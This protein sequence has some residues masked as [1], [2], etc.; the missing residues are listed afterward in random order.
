MTSESFFEIIEK[1]YKQDLPF[2]IYKKAE[3]SKVNAFLQNDAKAHIVNDFT[4]RGF[5]MSPFDS[6]KD[7]ILLPLS[8]SRQIELDHLNLEIF[9][10]QV[11][12]F[13]TETE[14]DKHKHIQLVQKGIDAIKSNR[15][16]KVVLSRKESVE[17][18]DNNPMGIY[19]KLLSSYPNAFV[20]CWYHP[21]F[22]LWLGATPETLV[23]IENNRLITMSL[24]GTKLY[25]GSL[26]IDWS[27]K[28][29]QEQQIVTDYIVENVTPHLTNLS[30]SDVKT[31]RAGS[32]VHLQT[33]ISGTLKPEDAILGKVISGLHPTPAV[34][35]RPKELARQ[36]VIDNEYYN[37]EF[38]TGFLG[39]LNLGKSQSRNRN[40]RNIENNVY[41]SVKKTTNLFVNL[42]CMQ[43][44][45]NSAQIYVGGG[46][47]SDSIPEN[48]W[49]ETVAKTS[50][51]K[52][53]L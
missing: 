5:V 32:L 39:E 11:K 35:G 21:S 46:I 36:F 38:Y 26:N 19:K 12:D 9:N 43:L 3:E 52:K 14:N 45:G 44:K 23:Q 20:Y 28:E 31:V 40:K 41:T 17:I 2:A 49:Q 4:E 51:I 15:F 48:E 1:H 18:E 13:N 24:A 33:T 7:V 6:N 37:R 8:D 47:T 22:G 53:V 10:P 30:V 29:L 34:C 16:D 42:R 25:E 27:P 50:T